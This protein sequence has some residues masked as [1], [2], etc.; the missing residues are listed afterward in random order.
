MKVG[1]SLKVLTYEL[2]FYNDDIPGNLG[3]LS[4]EMFYAVGLVVDA[5]LHYKKWT[6]EEAVAYMEHNTFS[7]PEVNI[8]STIDRT[9]VST[10]QACSYM[11]GRLK[12]LE[13][14]NK[15]K[16]EL[17]DAFQLKEFHN[18]VLKN[19]SLPLVLLEDQINQWIQEKKSL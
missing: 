10:G 15:A 1:R 17:G 3:R 8:E 19:G 5:G 2:G 14:R 9:I 6:R 11:V 13:L 16:Q 18:V 4:S 7:R 12:I